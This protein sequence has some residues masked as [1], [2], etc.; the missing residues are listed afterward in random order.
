M[1]LSEL[2]T[3]VGPIQPE[4]LAMATALSLGTVELALE[5]LRQL[6][7]I[8]GTTEDAGTS[9]ELRFTDMQNIGDYLG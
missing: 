1:I 9:W 5:T 4:E 7:L 6:D 3:R 8:E 2:V